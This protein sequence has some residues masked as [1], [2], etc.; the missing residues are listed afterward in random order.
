MQSLNAVYCG[1]DL[2]DLLRV[3]PDD[4]RHAVRDRPPMPLV[5]ACQF[6]LS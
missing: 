3:K 6:G 5:E 1:L 4:A 2:P